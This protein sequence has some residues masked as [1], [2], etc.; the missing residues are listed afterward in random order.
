M[1]ASSSY[2]AA[3]VKGETMQTRPE[4]RPTQRPLFAPGL[5]A[6]GGV[7]AIA[8]W[9]LNW[10]RFSFPETQTTVRTVFVGHRSVGLIFG[11][12]LLLRAALARTLSPRQAR[13]W[14]G[15]AILSGGFVAGY[16]IYDLATEQARMV[17][18]LVA[19]TATAL[20]IPVAAVQAEIN[21]QVAQG[22][23]KVTF[24][25]G[26]YVALAAAA[27]AVVGGIASLRKPLEAPADPGFLQDPLA[28]PHR[29][30]E[31]GAGLPEEILTPPAIPEPPS[32]W[33]PTP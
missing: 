21:R 3:P 23:V 22:Q 5:I 20:H 11:I 2:R 29:E 32:S 9:A 28:S 27:I 33:G 14:G 7:L 19:N 18:A 17:S 26:I 30:R 12:I 10:A 31:P 13:T 25:A 15:F 4:A 6:L 16:A 1:L 24:L 8:S